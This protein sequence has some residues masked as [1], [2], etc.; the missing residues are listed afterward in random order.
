M[1]W[2][3]RVKL[4]QAKARLQGV[5]LSDLEKYKMNNLPDERLSD[6]AGNARLGGKAVIL[7]RHVQHCACGQ[8]VFFLHAWEVQRARVLLGS[9]R[10]AGGLESMSWKSFGRLGVQSKHS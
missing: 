4:L 8:V 7:I 1:I 10:R 2:K 3:T 9:G 5:G 6:L